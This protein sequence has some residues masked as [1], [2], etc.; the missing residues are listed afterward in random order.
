MTKNNEL[1]TK[2]K[3]ESFDELVFSGRNKEYGA[4]Y[5]RKKYN[6]YIL[7]PFCSVLWL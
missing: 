3:A 5:L 2:E 6:K 4:Y 1:T 7:I